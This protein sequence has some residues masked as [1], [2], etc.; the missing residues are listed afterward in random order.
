[1]A[2]DT[3]SLELHFKDI[4]DHD[5]A[6]IIDKFPDQCPACNHGIDVKFVD[7]F[8]KSDLDSYGYRIQVIFRCP[9]IECQAVFIGYYTSGYFKPHSYSEYVFLKDCFIPSYFKEEHFDDEIEKLSPE[10]VKIYN[11]AKISDNIGLSLICGCGYRKSLEYLIKD[12]LISKDP[13]SKEEVQNHKLGWLIANKIDSE[14]IKLTAGLAKD[15]G[16]DETHYIKVMEDLSLEDL[17]KLVKLTTHW[18]SDE[19]MTKNYSSK[20]DKQKT[21]QQ[22]TSQS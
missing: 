12:Y 17:K 7:A 20:A 10:F 21:K 9:K 5:N 6:V 15:I 19:I 14:K 8:G 11:Q 2:R 16:N 22:D 13:Q 1:M 3:R 18:I 4:N